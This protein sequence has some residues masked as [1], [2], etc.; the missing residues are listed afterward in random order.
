MSSSNIGGNIGNDAS[1]IEWKR[2]AL[3]NLLEQMDDSIE[4]QIVK[5]D[6]QSRRR[7]DKIMKRAAKQEAQR[8]V[9]EEKCKAKQEAKQKAEEEKWKAEEEEKQKAEE[10]K[11]RAKEEYRA[12]AEVKRK[13]K[14][15][16]REATKVFRAKIAQGGVQGA[17]PKPHRA[18]S[19]C[20]PNKSIKGWYPPCD[21]C[22]R[23]GD[24]K[25][26]V[27]PPD[28]HSPTCGQCRLAKIK[29]HFEVSISMMERSTSGEK[30]KESETLATAIK[31]SPRGGEKHKR[32]KK[33]VAEATSTKE[34]EEA[35][36]S[37]LV[38]G[39]STRP[40][41]VTQ[42]LD[43]RLGEVIAAI[44][45]NTREL[46]WL[47]SKMDGFAWE[48]QQLADAGDRKGKGKARA[49]EPEDEEEQ[50]EK[51]EESEDGGDEDEEEDA[52]HDVDE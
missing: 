52:Q 43:R 39:P 42:V 47:R 23:S 31:T 32:T 28:A 29:C 19:H 4:V 16:T 2:V 15:D 40:D 50:S 12:Q 41:P 21:R 18:V 48:M 51:T 20:V 46:V 49:E 27:L 45:C 24:S 14:A 34:I 30:R 3:P 11:C 38:A 10:N 9:E 25:G 13:Q 37:F 6:E 7:H 22:R 8:K 33:V 36:G 26:C 44:D 5:V 1:G 35:M 17:K